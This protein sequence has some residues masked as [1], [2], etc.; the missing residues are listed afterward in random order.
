MKYE[1]I[2]LEECIA[3]NK[4]AKMI[5]ECDADKKEVKFKREEE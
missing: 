4:I 2:T 3:Y 1:N 5:F